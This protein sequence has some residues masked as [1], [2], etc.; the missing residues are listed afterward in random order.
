[1][2]VLMCHTCPYFSE[3]ECSI[4]IL[5]LLNCCGFVLPPVIIY[6]L[7]CVYSYY[8]RK[9]LS[10]LEYQIDL[11]SPDITKTLHAGTVPSNPKPRPF[12][13]AI[14]LRRKVFKNLISSRHGP[15]KSTEPGRDEK[16]Q[17][18]I[19]LWNDGGPLSGLHRQCTCM[20]ASPCY[21]HN[22]VN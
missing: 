17:E 6:I 18:T 14:L 5:C 7:S 16:N 22:K 4:L 21:L 2:Y 20:L 9:N 19:L 15:V 11:L 8:E 12:K 3:E 10:Y 1:M 13:G